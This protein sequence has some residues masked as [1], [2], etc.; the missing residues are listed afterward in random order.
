MTVLHFQRRQLLA[1][2]L[3]LSALPLAAQTPAYPSK[4]V[5]VV[6]PFGAGGVG[7]LTARAVSAELAKRLGQPF[8][9]RSRHLGFRAAQLTEVAGRDDP[10]QQAEHHQHHQQF[11]QGKAVLRATLSVHGG[12]SSR[13]CG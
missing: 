11:Q 5:R 13:A 4:A 10:G 3:A 8:A 7:D 1:A 9:L 2:A 6:V 12:A